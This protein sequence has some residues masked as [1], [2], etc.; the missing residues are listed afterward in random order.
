MS[1]KGSGRLK[2]TYLNDMS[3]LEAAEAFKETDI[4]ILPMGTTHTHDHI[5]MGIDTYAGE[6]FGRRL[7]ERTNT[8]C[9]PTLPYAW[10][11]HYMDIPG[12]IN[13]REEPTRQIIYDVC[14]S[15][16]RWGINKIVVSQGHSGPARYVCE[17]VSSHL[18]EKYNM[19]MVITEWYALRGML[20]IDSDS[21]EVRMAGDVRDAE[22]CVA[23]HVLGE[24]SLYKKTVKVPL[25][26]CRAMSPRPNLFGS[27]TKI[28]QARFTGMILGNGRA[29]VPLMFS[30]AHVPL[31]PAKSG[32]GSCRATA[33]RGAEMCNKILDWQVEFVEELKKVK[34][35]KRG[36]YN[37]IE[38]YRR[39]VGYPTR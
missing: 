25:E 32:P 13:V 26:E 9:L 36:A 23:I 4:A 5:P 27:D 33:E 22:T 1:Q 39:S 21:S 12:A 18:R 7:A 29:A 6:W 31:M 24:E 37:F 2:K 34:I 15:V 14:E 8:I 19:L 16:H 11:P 30:E 20:G 3:A 17:T 38:E 10:M 35:P 28:K